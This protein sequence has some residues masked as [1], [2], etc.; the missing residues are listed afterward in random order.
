R[1]E[2]DVNDR[3]LQPIAVGG[4]GGIWRIIV[5]DTVPGTRADFREICI[6]ELR[7]LGRAPEPVS[8]G[9]P[10]LWIGGFHGM[11]VTGIDRALERLRQ[12]DNT[13]EETA[14]VEELGPTIRM[15]ERAT[16]L[17]CP[18]ID[19]GIHE[20]INQLERQFRQF[21]GIGEESRSCEGSVAM[22]HLYA[23]A[24]D[25]SDAFHAVLLDVH[26]MYF[27]WQ[28]RCKRSLDEAS[29][30]T[31]AFEA[32]F[33][34]GTVEVERILDALSDGVPHRDSGPFQDCRGAC[35]PEATGVEERRPR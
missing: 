34:N 7:A 33:R 4:A 5:T 35:V 10:V 14:Y 32:P 28:R 27:F 19:T 23:D 1:A 6:S 2:L 31:D 24:N 16:Y 22:G 20:R 30:R 18:P 8:G 11:S 29:G 9:P 15:L 13:T 17:R 3:G 12:L 25:A 21:V 26:R